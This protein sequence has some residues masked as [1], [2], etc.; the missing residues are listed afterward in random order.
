MKESS[1][2]LGIKYSTAKNIVKSFKKRTS[3]SITPREIIFSL[4]RLA[5][6]QNSY[7]SERIELKTLNMDDNFLGSSTSSYDKEFLEFDFKIYSPSIFLR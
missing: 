2:I 7:K 6:N 5:A 4:E 3:D 1:K